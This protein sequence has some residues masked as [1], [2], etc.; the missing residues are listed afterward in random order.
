MNAQIQANTNP[1]DLIA[2]ARERIT[3]GLKY[4]NDMLSS[5]DLCFAD[6]TLLIELALDKDEAY[7][8]A[9]R[10]F[11][12]GAQELITKNHIANGYHGEPDFLALERGRRY[13]K[14]T[15]AYG[16]SQ[17]RS[18]HCFIDRTNGDVLKTESWKKPAK[19]ARGNI[20][21]ASNGV[22]AM[23]VYGARYLK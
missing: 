9:L 15:R 17:G 10:A 8:G 2:S 12:N 21:D 6:A 20:Y 5:R 3:T 7:E 18:A 16:S 23:G 4:G 14:V 22:D 13:D 19:H 11:M 1:A